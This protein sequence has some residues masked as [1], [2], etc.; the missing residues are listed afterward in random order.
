LDAHTGQ[1]IADLS[2]TKGADG[3]HPHAALLAFADADQRLVSV[4]PDG[5]LYAWSLAEGSA[6]AVALEGEVGPL[7]ALAA[8]GRLLAVS[9]GGGW[10]KEVRL[11]RVSAADHSAE[12]V[13]DLA[14][15]NDVWSA[16]FAPRGSLFAY[17]TRIGRLHLQSV[18]SGEE[19]WQRQV[20]H[21]AITRLAISADERWVAV[22]SRDAGIQLLSAVTG[23]PVA[24]WMPE[25]PAARWLTFSPDSRT[26]AAAPADDTVR[27][28]SVDDR[29]AT[30]IVETGRHGARQL[31][32]TPD[33]R[34]A[35][36]GNNVALWEVR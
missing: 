11:W 36:A 21:A 16:A 4:A 31:A 34:L 32:F 35:T 1:V 10:Q 28:W 12:I 14:A 26:L 29:R 22:Y 17:G 3:P 33:G 19:L 5:A 23:E 30:L 18:E 20:G 27:L 24:S 9:L 15:K 8:D 25:G 7:R 6:Q 2:N 13:R